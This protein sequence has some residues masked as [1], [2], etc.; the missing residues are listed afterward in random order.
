[1]GHTVAGYRQTAGRTVHPHIR[2]AYFFLVLGFRR[3]FGSSPH[4]WG[5]RYDLVFRGRWLR[6]IPTYVGHTPRS[7]SLWSP[8]TV[9]PHIRGAYG[10]A[11]RVQ[12]TQ[13]VHPHIRGAYAFK[14]LAIYHVDG[15]S[16]H[17]WGIRR[18]AP[19]R[20]DL[21]PVHPHIRGAYRSRSVKSH[22]GFG[23]SPHTW[24]IRSILRIRPPTGRF[25]PT[26]VGHTAAGRAGSRPGPV[27]PHIRGAY[28]FV[29]EP[30][31]WEDGSSPHTWGIQV[32]DFLKAGPDRFIT[33]YV[34]H[35]GVAER[36]QP[37][38]TVHPHIRGAYT[39]NM[40]TTKHYDG[41][42]PHTW[43]IRPR[44]AGGCPWG[45]FIPTYVGHTLDRRKKN[46][47]FQPLLL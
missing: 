33:T 39:N 45:G 20:D 26:Y 25:I 46:G 30:R 42:S 32:P 36:V 4:T 3:C 41:S 15:S 35:T 10:V 17:T 22:S 21:R 31:Q 13:S 23:S 5:I 1:M 38:P 8:I 6:F 11:E 19:G 9:H 40:P 12:P 27:H 37:A 14:A 16:P 43:G 28:P 47:W 29:R 18:P 24:G 7:C 44:A 34:G 2:G